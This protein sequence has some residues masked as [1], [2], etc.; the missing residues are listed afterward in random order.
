M[1]GPSLG[2]RLSDGPRSRQKCGRELLRGCVN[3]DLVGGLLGDPDGVAVSRDEL[4]RDAL[5]E[6]KDLGVLRDELVEDFV[7]V[8]D[9][10]VT[11][12]MVTLRTSVVSVSTPSGTLLPNGLK[13]MITPTAITATTMT[14]AMTRPALTGTA[15]RFSLRCC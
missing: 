3:A 15:I 9:L 14:P 6:H 5:V 8:Y 1:R 2:K 4:A 12:L 10:V 7:D 11:P 13:P